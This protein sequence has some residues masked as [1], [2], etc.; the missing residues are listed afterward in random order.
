LILG[1]FERFVTFIT[2]AWRY[3]PYLSNIESAHARYNKPR[4]Q[5]FGR[6]SSS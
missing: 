2:K 1:L 6:A 5:A 4:D 3:G